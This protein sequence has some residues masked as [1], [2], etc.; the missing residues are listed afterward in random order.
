MRT[1]LI[2][3][4]DSFTYNLFQYLAASNGMAPTVI[5]NDEMSWEEASRLDFDNIVISPGPGR[6]QRKEDL[7]LAADA[8][9]H[10]DVPILG[11]CLGHQAMGYACGAAVHLAVRPM[12]GR[13][14]LISHGGQ[15][16]FRGIPSPFEAVRYHSL[17]VTQLPPTL[18][19]L[20]WAPDGTLM[21]LRHLHKPWWGVQ[22]HP[23]SI[24]S[25]Y[26]ARLLRNFR[27]LSVQWRRSRLCSERVGV[28]QVARAREDAPAHWEVRARC[29]DFI[30]E[31]EQAFRALFADH[32]PSFWLDSSMSGP[33]IAR[34]S[35]MGDA[36]GPHSAALRYES[37]TTS[38]HIRQPHSEE[39]R[40]QSIFDYLRERLG[41]APTQPVV[42]LPFDFFGGFVGYFGY[43]LKGELEGDPVHAAPAADAAGLFVDRFLAFDH[44]DARMWIVSLVP[45]GGPD[46]HSAWVDVITSQ[47]HRLN[48]METREPDPR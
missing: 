3:N 17:G 19:A 47:L 42:P 29:M 8:L 25:E 41:A 38:L 36:T 30:V 46:L 10:A 33:G 39:S 13:V 9:A 15:G 12:H 48:G 2:D 40:R 45:P 1:L 22:F 5:R 26:G 7:G 4:H 28:A 31:P 6:P 27:E 35:Y 37:A 44:E 20:A 32:N 23:E 24:C 11:V 43:E 34:F 18:E 21:A 14:D 16:L